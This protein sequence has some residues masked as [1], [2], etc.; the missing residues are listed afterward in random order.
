MKIDRDLITEKLKQILSSLYETERLAKMIHEK[1]RISYI[2]LNDSQMEELY[3]V[4]VIN[5][6][7]NESQLEFMRDVIEKLNE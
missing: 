6:R 4:I 2:P 7:F 5:L 1:I 3:E